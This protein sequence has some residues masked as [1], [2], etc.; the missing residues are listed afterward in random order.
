[1]I[2]L[3]FSVLYNHTFVSKPSYSYFLKSKKRYTVSLND[4]KALNT[5][6]YLIHV[7]N[8]HLKVIC[9]DLLLVQQLHKTQFFFPLP[10]KK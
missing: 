1:M 2:K 10:E 7:L 6:Q 5:P 9:A 3:N 8:I 4:T